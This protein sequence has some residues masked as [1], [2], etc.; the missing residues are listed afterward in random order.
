MM[1]MTSLRDQAPRKEFPVEFRNNVVAVTREGTVWVASQFTGDIVR[2]DANGDTLWHGQIPQP[3]VQAAHD[4]YFAAV[5]SDP[6]RIHVPQL[7]TDAEVVNGMLVIS[8]R[9]ESG[10][11]LWSYDAESGQRQGQ[12]VIP[13]IAGGAFAVD[14][15]RRRTYIAVPNQAMLVAVTAVPIGTE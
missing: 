15:Q 11:E 6:Q 1:S 10:T 4:A 5:E 9:S 12:L 3:L 8:V 14:T 7:I 13:G 2:L